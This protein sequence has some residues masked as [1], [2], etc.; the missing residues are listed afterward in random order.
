MKTPKKSIGFSLKKVST[1]QFAIIEE[2]FNDKGKIRLN[3]S[4]RYA[5]D[6]IQKYVAV[7]TSF[8]FDSDTKPFLIVEAS[9]HFKINDTA[10]IQMFNSVT[11]TLVIP[12]GFLRHLAMLTVG[13]SRGILHAKTEGTCFNKYVLPTIN[14]TLIIKE[15]AT[16]NFNKLEK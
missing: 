10:W 8:I 13:T 14:V 7:F 4:L 11:N 5:A 6:D 12:K 9:C 3:T 2:G 15:D 16:F 1:E